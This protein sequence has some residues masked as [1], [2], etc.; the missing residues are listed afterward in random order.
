MSG[1]LTDLLAIG[2]LVPTLG[3][4]LSVAIEDISMLLG[5]KPERNEVSSR[6]YVSNLVDLVGT[7]RQRLGLS[8]RL[9]EVESH[10]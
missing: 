2:W 1:P 3:K 9:S 5:E 6:A 8:S 4:S 7:A 10:Q